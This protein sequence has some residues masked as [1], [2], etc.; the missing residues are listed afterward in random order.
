MMASGLNTHYLSEAL[1]NFPNLKDVTVCQIDF[2]NTVTWG[3]VALL[4]EIR[5]PL[6][7]E[8]AKWDS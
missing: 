2:D 4:K 5:H 3:W 8:S 1:S 7:L 6:P